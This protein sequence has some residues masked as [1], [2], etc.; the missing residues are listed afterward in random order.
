MTKQELRVKKARNLRYK[1]PIA[2]QMNLETIKENLWEMQDACSDVRYFF[3]DSEDP[4]TLLGELLGDED[5]AV[6]FRLMF[7]DLSSECDPYLEDLDDAEWDEYIE[8]YFNLFM[9]LEDQTGYL[10]GYDTYEHDYFGLQ[11]SWEK[12]MAVEAAH[13]K[14]KKELTKDKLLDLFQ[15]C[16]RIMTSYCAIQYRYD[17][18]KASLD[19]IREQNA[20]HLMAVK[21]INALYTK[22]DEET[23]GFQF[24]WRSEAYSKLDEMIKAMPQEAFL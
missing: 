15:K 16:M 7:S 14:L 4:E 11:A 2:T 20:A 8:Q 21:E 9:V 22:V 12:E 17:C 24:C 3:D 19:I 23:D 18:L 13:E 1:K 5:E 6:E 10:A